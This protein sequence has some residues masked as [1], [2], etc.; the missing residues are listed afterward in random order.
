VPSAAR[1]PAWVFSTRADG[2]LAIDAPDVETA[3]GAL[4]AR[5]GGPDAAWNWLVQVHGADVVVAGAAGEHQGTE[6]DALV[7]A[8]PGV[9]LAVQTAD[10]GAIV[11]TSP[12]G[13]VGAVHAGWRGLAAG[14]VEATVVAMRELGAGEVV[15]HAGPMIHPECYEFGEDD[16]AVVAGALGPGVRG[17]TARGTHA[18]DLPGAVAAAVARAGATLATPSPACTACD[19]TRYYSHRARRET[20]RLAAVVWLDG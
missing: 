20:A 16:L 12:E 14:V 8:E 13:V 9:P 11:L 18:L 17:R 5:A 4:L 7:S 10:C 19:A 6:A 1:R 2:D 3:R 15:A